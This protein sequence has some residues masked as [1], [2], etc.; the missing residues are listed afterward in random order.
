MNTEDFTLTSKE[1]LEALLKGNTVKD[2]DWGYFY[3][4]PSL[5]MLE[6]GFCNEHE[7]IR[8]RKNDVTTISYNELENYEGFM[9]VDARFKIVP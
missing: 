2:N 4:I 9:G 8:S 7:I 6:N 5:D 1:A 3:Y